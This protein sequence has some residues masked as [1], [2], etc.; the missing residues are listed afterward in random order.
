[1]D[2][3]N[4]LFSLQDRVAL[5]TG[6]NRGLGRA[7]ALGLQ[8]A[9]GRVAVT[10]RD[11]EKNAAVSKELEDP[12]AVFSVD[13]REEEAVRAAVGAVV[14]RFGGLDILINNAGQFLGGSLLDLSYE[15]WDAVLQTHLSGTFLCSK[16][17]AKAMIEGGAGGK[18][19]NIGS[20]YSIYGS[21]RGVC[22]GTAK[23]GILGLTRAL[24]VELAPHRIQ[25]NAILPGLF[26]TDLTADLLGTPLAE[27]LRR[28]TPAA[29]WGQPEDLVGTAVFL[30]S[31]A[32]DFVTGAGIPV[33]GGYSIA[34]RI[35]E[36]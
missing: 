11:P 12:G 19:I 18:I 13:V 25:V 36:E 34:D 21:P 32:S 26:E 27:Q 2:S 24:A 30:A 1:M 31:S 33:D 9:G 14:D 35:R 29:R 23:T 15:D 20:M 10:G 16:H 3:L 6:G 22:Y 28:K 8:A 7:M 5:V 17:C 4:D